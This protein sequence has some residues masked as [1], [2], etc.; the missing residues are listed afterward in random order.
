[1]GTEWLIY[2]SKLSKLPKSADMSAVR[3]TNLSSIVQLISYK[4]TW[5]V[6]SFNGDCLSIP[7]CAGSCEY[8]FHEIPGISV[9]SFLSGLRKENIKFKSHK[10]IWMK[11][12]IL[13]CC[14][15]GLCWWRWAWCRRTKGWR[16]PRPP[17]SQLFENTKTF[18][19]KWPI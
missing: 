14:L 3:D 7:E 13:D 2:K 17:P 11:W 9:E 19:L 4:G 6:F 16:R 18:R 12:R 5:S 15:R 8:F 10:F 1:M